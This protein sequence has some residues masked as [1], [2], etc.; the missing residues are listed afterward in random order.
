[1]GAGNAVQVYTHWRNLGHR[2]HRLLVHMALTALD[3][4]N[5]PK[6][7]G[8]REKLA[9]ALGYDVPE[10]PPASERG[11]WAEEVHRQ[12]AKAFQAVKQTLRELIKAGAIIRIRQGQYKSNAEYEL[13]LT[14]EA[15]FETRGRI[16]NATP[17]DF[18]VSNARVPAEQDP[19]GMQ[20]VTEQPPKGVTERPSR[21]VTEQPPYE[22]E[23]KEEH[24]SG[25]SRRRHTGTRVLPQFKT[26]MN[27]SQSQFERE[28]TRQTQALQERMRA[29]G[30]P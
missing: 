19:W 26:L 30:K 20:G 18:R 12:R 15:A 6:Y 17:Q 5:P 24:S 21:G 4:E 25:V 22:Y 9:T 29:E 3:S 7:W 10:E 27:D 8:G 13:C 23:E 1:M 14:P 11:P 2:P 28:R 16:S